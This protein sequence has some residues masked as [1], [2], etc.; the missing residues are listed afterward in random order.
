MHSLI[1]DVCIALTELSNNI[2]SQSRN[3]NPGVPLSQNKGWHHPAISPDELEQ[4]PRALASRIEKANIESL[5]GLDQKAIELIPARL[6]LLQQKSNII[7]MFNGHGHQAIPS[8]WITIEWVESLFEPVLGYGTVDNPLIP[9]ALKRKVRSIQTR[10]DNLDIK[11]EKLEEMISQIQSAHSAAESLPADLADL[12]EARKQLTTSVNSARSEI[13]QAIDDEKKSFISST[14]S[15]NSKLEA[16]EVLL[17]K[18]DKRSGI[19]DQQ[20]EAAKKLLDDSENAY[21]IA[22]TKGLSG[23]FHTRARNL[24]ISMWFWVLGLVGALYVGVITGS[25]RISTLSSLITDENPNID[26]IIIQLFLSL[27]NL[28]APIWFAWL[29]TKQISQRFR[30]AEDYNY[31]ASVAK[32]YEGYRREAARIDPILEAKLMHSAIS[33][34]DEAPLRHVDDRYHAT[35]WQELIASAEFREAVEKIPELKNKFSDI[36]NK[37]IPD[38]L[39]PKSE[40]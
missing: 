11:K 26:L 27:L 4:V 33:R 1:N 7:N 39:K 34:L 10:V 40:K 20:T 37:S 18:A 23:A 16:I 24:S 29:S 5:E 38:S 21:S 22:V 12:Q 32:A 3:Q 17:Q 25:N 6:Q 15:A 9:N 36:I 13:E 31:K 28:G 8:F 35:P 14:S 2:N 30:L 19:L